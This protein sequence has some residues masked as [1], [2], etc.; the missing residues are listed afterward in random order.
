MRTLIGTVLIAIGLVGRP[1]EAT[2]ERRE[3][4]PVGP[5]AG[6]A[7]LIGGIALIVAGR[8]RA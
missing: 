5:L 2:A 6:A 3:T 7:A 4:I 8:R 1:I